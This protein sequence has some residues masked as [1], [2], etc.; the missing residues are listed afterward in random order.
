[1]SIETE[2]LQGILTRM[3]PSKDLVSIFLLLNICAYIVTL[4]VQKW[5]ASKQL[6]RPSTP[7]LEKPAPRPGAREKVVRP[8]GGKLTCS[9][10]VF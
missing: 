9:N 10:P 1:M 3:T 8:F 5:N 4:G 6:P 2:S 7:D